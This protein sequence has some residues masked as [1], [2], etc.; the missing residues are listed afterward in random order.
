LQQGLGKEFTDEVREAW[1]AAYDLL[2]STMK[3]AAKVAA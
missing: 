1:A 2:A 3:D